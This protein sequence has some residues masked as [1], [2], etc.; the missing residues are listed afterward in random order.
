[1]QEW[2]DPCP[3]SLEIHRD[4]EVIQMCLVLATVRWHPS[5]AH[6]DKRPEQTSTL[7]KGNRAIMVAW[8]WL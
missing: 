1:M 7:R 2:R 3:E 5:P 6:L 4:T 8:A